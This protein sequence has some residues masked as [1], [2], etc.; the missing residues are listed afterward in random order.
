MSTSRHLQSNRTA[1]QKASLAVGA[2][3]VLVG[4]LGFIP[5]ITTDYGT[6]QFAG[7]E[8][9]A[10][11][12]GIFQVSVLHNIVHL[13]YGV[14]GIVL[15][16]TVSAARTYLMLGGVTYLL[17]SLYGFL[18]GGGS[19]ANFVPVNVADNWLHLG[20]GLGMAALALTLTPRTTK[21]ADKAH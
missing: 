4:V 20:L 17:L 1:V 16:K 15:A 5:G 14:G 13:L 21:R 10:M 11:L 2:V 6:L 8:S 7:H 9:E 18:I 12:L 3:F 19:A